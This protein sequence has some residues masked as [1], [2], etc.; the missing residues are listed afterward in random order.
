MAALAPSPT[1]KNTGADLRLIAPGGG[2]AEDPRARGARE[3][4]TPHFFSTEARGP[5]RNP[6]CK[7]RDHRRAVPP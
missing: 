4:T 7:P 6:P 5:L 1:Y 3:P 2:C